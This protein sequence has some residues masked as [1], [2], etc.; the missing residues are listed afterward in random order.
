MYG[1]PEELAALARAL[2]AAP[3]HKLALLPAGEASIKK[4]GEPTVAGKRLTAYDISGLGFTPVPVWLDQRNEMFAS[5]SS[6]LS[7]V[8]EGHDAALPQLL[9]A[10]DEWHAAAAR[11]MAARLAHKPSGGGLVITN[12]R[13]A[14]SRWAPL[15]RRNWSTSTPPAASSS[16]ACGTCTRTSATTTVR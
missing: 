7:V 4:L 2:L 3:N 8:A 6:W 12:A 11:E 15:T 14:S 1:P 16:P 9:K 13:V 5:A 10:Q